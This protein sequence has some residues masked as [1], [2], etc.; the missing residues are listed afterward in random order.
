MK[1]GTR[2][3]FTF[4]QEN[5]DNKVFFFNSK[6]SRVVHVSCI[7]CIPSRVWSRDQLCSGDS[8]LMISNSVSKENVPAPIEDDAGCVGAELGEEVE[9]GEHQAP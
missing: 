8:C 3:I 5:G 9:D 1:E 7:R 6:A 2:E 4:I